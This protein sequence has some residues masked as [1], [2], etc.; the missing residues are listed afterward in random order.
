[1]TLIVVLLE[2]LKAKP[3]RRPLTV[4]L[5]VELLNRHLKGTLETLESIISLI[6]TIFKSS[7][8]KPQK[9]P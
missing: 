2:L 7:L 1:M 4:T 3:Q 6:V 8:E 9:R 5:V